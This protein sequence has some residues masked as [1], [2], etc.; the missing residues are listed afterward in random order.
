MLTF[1]QYINEMALPRP[2]DRKKTYYHGTSKEEAIV[3]IMKYGIEPL[4]L[5]NDTKYMGSNFTP[6][7]NK[8]YITPEI[9]YAV[10]Y[11]LGGDFIGHEF[12]RSRSDEEYGYLCVINGKNLGDNIQ[13]DEDSIGELLSQGKIKWLTDLANRYL[14]DEEFNEDD[15]DEYESQSL[16][17]AV[18]DGVAEAQTIAGKKLVG[19]MTDDQKLDLISKGAHIAH[20]GKL[21]PNEIWKIKKEDCKLLDKDATNFFTIATKIR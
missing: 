14:S 4:D 7:K 19:Y 8:V 2:A 13:P 3:G 6:V 5:T 9:R 20:E 15:E 1:I 12:Y 18:Y 16:L 11:A 10:I 17:D 21:K